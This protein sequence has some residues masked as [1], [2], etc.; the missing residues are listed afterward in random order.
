[1][2]KEELCLCL[3]CVYLQSGAKGLWG[4][5]NDCIFH[6]KQTLKLYI[7]NVQSIESRLLAAVRT[8]GYTNRVVW[9]FCFCWKW[10][11]LYI[12]QVCWLKDFEVLCALSCIVRG[13]CSQCDNT[14]RPDPLLPQPKTRFYREWYGHCLLACRSLHNALLHECVG[15][16]SLVW[17][18]HMHITSMA[19][20]SGHMY[21]TW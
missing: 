3:C 8:S 1:M 15:F 18:C 5:G 9:G 16:Y 7:M 13:T 6:W 11:W 17:L 12:L 19:S 10:A 20:M 14:A 4:N 21:E 2:G